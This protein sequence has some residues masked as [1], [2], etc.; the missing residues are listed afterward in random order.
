MG[1]ELG[2][3][4]KEF[5]AAIKQMFVEQA[6]GIVKN[7]GGKVM[8]AAVSIISGLSR[9]YVT[10]LINNKTKASREWVSTPVRILVTWVAQDLESVISYFSED[11]TPDIATLAKGVTLDKFIKVILDE[12]VRLKQVSVTDNKVTFIPVSIDENQATGKETL[13]LDFTDN[14]QA[15]ALAGVGD[16]TNTSYV[17]FLEQAVKVDGIHK[18]SAKYLSKFNVDIWKEVYKENH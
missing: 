14:L 8:D 10:Q 17:P 3:T 1:L 13:L 18:N 9:T 16:L 15:H 11:D 12:L 6:N 4:Y 7:K 5:N 2:I